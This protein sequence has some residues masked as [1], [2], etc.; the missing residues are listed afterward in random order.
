M[1]GDVPPRWLFSSLDER[2][3]PTQGFVR[4]RDAREA[5]AAVGREYPGVR[6]VR[7]HTTATS[8]GILDGILE[9]AVAQFG[10]KLD[11]KALR[12]LA[13]EMVASQQAHAEAPIRWPHGFDPMRGRCW[14]AQARC[15]WPGGL[16]WW[17]VMGTALVPACLLAMQWWFHR[18]GVMFDEGTRAAARGDR[19]RLERMATRLTA[20][21]HRFP[22]VR[23]GAWELAVRRAWF[24]AREQG[25]DEARRQLLAHPFCP[26]DER[27]LAARMYILHLARGDHQRM[28]EVLRA[29]LGETPDDPEL[30]F[31]LALCEARQ[32]HADAARQRLDQVP[33]QALPPFV[34]SFFDWIEGL[35]ALHDPDRSA[36]ATQLLQRACQGMLARV[37]AQ[38]VL[39]SSLVACNCDLALALAMSGRKDAA[40][41]T[42]EP[43]WS[44]AQHTE[45]P[46]RLAMIRALIDGLPQAAPQK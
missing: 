22:F 26:R 46:Q 44:M 4:A 6:D 3:K 31:D 28:A 12:R 30:L 29:L 34:G 42:L 19:Q 43:V 39:W 18:L 15:S 40:R 13:R 10:G 7:L 23:P 17:V 37:E 14:S 32:G 16:P 38:P 45:E 20:I 36:A 8:A 27:K 21:G 41:K 33:E 11:D 25:H 9:T 1:S 5:L 24:V 35:I 2:G